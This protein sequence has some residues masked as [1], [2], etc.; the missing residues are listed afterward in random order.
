MIYDIHFFHNDSV[1]VQTKVISNIKMKNKKQ[2]CIFVTAS[3]SHLKDFFILIFICPL[4]HVQVH[5]SIGKLCNIILY[6]AMRPDVPYFNP[7]SDNAPG[8]GLRTLWPT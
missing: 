1:T 5:L 7:L 2:S 8:H 6:M 4:L 3:L